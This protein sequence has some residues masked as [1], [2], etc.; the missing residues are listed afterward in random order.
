MKVFGKFANAIIYKR[1]IQFA[2]KLLS[3]NYIHL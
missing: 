1:K 3:F 2:A